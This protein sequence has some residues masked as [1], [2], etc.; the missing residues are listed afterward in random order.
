VAWSILGYLC[1]HPYAKDTAAGVAKWWLSAE[2]PEMTRSEVEEALSYL[3]VCGWLITF[4]NGS[5]HPIYGLN[6]VRR[7]ELQRFLSTEA[8]GKPSKT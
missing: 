3:T 6:P 5:P 4:R 7:E 8:G 1:L 2:G